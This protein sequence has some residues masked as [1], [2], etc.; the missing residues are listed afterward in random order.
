MI[1]SRTQEILKWLREHRP[2][3]YADLAARFDLGRVEI[4]ES[5]T[6]EKYNGE[7]CPGK[8]PVEIVQRGG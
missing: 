4:A 7:W 5:I 3:I 8:E 6:V 1:P 2:E